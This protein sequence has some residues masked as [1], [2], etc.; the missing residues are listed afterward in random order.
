M[1]AKKPGPARPPPPQLSETSR[2]IFDNREQLNE[3]GEK[4]GN[5]VRLTEPPDPTK[6]HPEPPDELLYVL[7]CIFVRI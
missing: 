1:A 2:S 6:F 7:I 4:L 5:L 3:R